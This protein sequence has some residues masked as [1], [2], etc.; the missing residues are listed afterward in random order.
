MR[1]KKRLS[2]EG[3]DQGIAGLCMQRHQ[4]NRSSASLEARFRL[5]ALLRKRMAFTSWALPRSSTRAHAL[6]L[7]YAVARISL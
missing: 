5:M 1:G 2:F 3:V 4:S 7:D 6:A